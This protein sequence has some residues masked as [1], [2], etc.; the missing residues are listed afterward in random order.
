MN[1]NE[2]HLINLMDN[3]LYSHKKMI[4]HIIIQVLKV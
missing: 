3:G 4:T 1:I 2:S